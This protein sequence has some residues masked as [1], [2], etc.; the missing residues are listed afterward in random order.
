[1]IGSIAIVLVFILQADSTNFG[2]GHRGWVAAHAL[3][4]A[5][6]ATFTNHFVGNT[7]NF[8]AEDKQDYIY[9]DRYPPFF[10]AI[11]H[12][13]LSTFNLPSEKISFS[14]QWM[15]GIYVITFLLTYFLIQL[16]L[17]NHVKSLGLTL[18]I[19]SGF[20]YIQF[21][22]MFHFD[23]PALLGMIGFLLALKLCELQKVRPWV[24][25][26]VATIA[27]LMGRGY[28]TCLVVAFWF[29][30]DSLVLLKKQGIQYF[31][32]SFFKQTSFVT[33]VSVF[34]FSS[35]A[36]F[37][38]IY[39]EAR[40]RDVS[41][42]ETSIVTSAQRRTG[43]ADTYDIP[44]YDFTTGQAIRILE[45]SLP[46]PLNAT[47]K[48]RN[49][50][51]GTRALVRNGHLKTI[52][53]VTPVLYLT[54]LT[55]IGL[56]LWRHKENI[57]TTFFGLMTPTTTVIALSGFAWM[58]PMKRLA[59]PHQYTNMYYIGLYI[60]MG[61]FLWTFLQGR[62]RTIAVTAMAFLLFVCSLVNV[63]MFYEANETY[64]P[65]L[66]NDFD[67]I[68]QELDLRSIQKI[69]VDRSYR[70]YVTG[71]PYALC[72]YVGDRFI[73]DDKSI[74]ISNKRE[75]EGYKNLTPENRFY[76]LLESNLTI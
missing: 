25:V 70:E 29:A 67:E 40:K 8:E 58:F 50:G 63:K 12:Q 69:G 5:D 23:Q 35:L 72:F 66:T 62:K 32:T 49:F 26:L 6:K 4:I 18:F 31:M 65:D 75:L 59:A 1:M 30:L 37:A 60:V 53:F 27:C 2:T 19:A 76:F 41:L 15:N 68:R 9:F 7:C 33:L 13:A 52:F 17:K 51:E 3:A 42:S 64:G 61:V 47:R 10:S 28:A 38:N 54:L 21:K 43:I 48:Y 45:G 36:L 55:L 44:W 71:S 57:K 16:F 46:F 56:A 22:D 14:R 20:F 74:L 11:S 34:I 39:S 73:S 24:V